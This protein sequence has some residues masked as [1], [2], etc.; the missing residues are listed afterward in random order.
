MKGNAEHETRRH[1]ESGESLLWSGVPKQG[2]FLRASDSFMIPFSLLWGGFAFF[3]EYVVITK[4]ASLLFV[5]FGVPFV[6][7]GLY[8]IAG[9]F[10][11]DAKMRANTYYALT[12]RRAIIVSGLFTQ[13]TNSI[14]LRTLHD[15]SLKE[16]RDRTGT[17]ILGR[18]NP[19]NDLYSGIQWPDM[20]QFRVPSF[21][22]IDNAK[23]VHDQILQAHRA[24]NQKAAS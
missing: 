6:L 1:L 24:E 8:I 12:D 5:L 22:R 15:I 10:F 9:R 18:S 4:G 17:V 14:P 23:Y 11:V 7:I 19:L 21:E 3:W 16:R 13:S 20:S 2:I